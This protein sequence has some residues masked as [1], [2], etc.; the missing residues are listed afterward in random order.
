MNEKFVNIP[1]LPEKGAKEIADVINKH[2]CNND[3]STRFWQVRSEDYKLQTGFG[4]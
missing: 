3:Y 1:P 4:L 2:L